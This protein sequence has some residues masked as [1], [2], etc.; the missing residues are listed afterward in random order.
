MVYINVMEEEAIVMG[1]DVKIVEPIKQVPGI[2]AI[3]NLPS[4]ERKK[5]ID[6]INNFFV[7]HKLVKNA[8]GRCNFEQGFRYFGESQQSKGRA[9]EVVDDVYRRKMISSNDA[10]SIIEY[11]LKYNETKI[12]DFLSKINKCEQ[13]R[14]VEIK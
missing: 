9:L 10:N 2:E 3:E 7:E 11:V 6:N 5:I 8:L 4:I 12:K 14:T 13:S 1:V